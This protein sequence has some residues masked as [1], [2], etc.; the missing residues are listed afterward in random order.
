MEQPV[1][2]ERD[3]PTVR[4]DAVSLAPPETDHFRAQL[5]HMIRHLLPAQPVLDPITRDEVEQDV[6]EFVAAQ[7][8]GMPGYIRVPYRALLLVFEWL[9]A[10]GSLRP[11]SALPAERQQRCLAAWSNSHVSL[12]RDTIKLVRSC[13]LL[14]YLD[15]HLV[16][17]RLET[18]EPED[19]Q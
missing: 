18:M 14:Q 15:H 19:W 13:A 8:G 2:S 7:I 11:F 1:T 17:S 4:K 16:L 12:I 3:L 5:F 6:V 10:L 9:P